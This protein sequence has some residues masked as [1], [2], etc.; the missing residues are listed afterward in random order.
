MIARR[1]G[2]G[3][4]PTAF[5]LA[6]VATAF[7]ALPIPVAAQES[8]ESPAF[9]TSEYGAIP[10]LYE[11]RPMP[12]SSAG[13]LILYRLSARGSVGERDEAAWIT[14]LLLDPFSAVEDEVFL[15]D[16]PAVLG[17]LGFPE[18]ERGRYSYLDL[19]PVLEPL[20]ILAVS[21]SS[22][23]RPLDATE[24]E[25][26]ALANNVRLFEGLA[27]TFDVFRAGSGP[28]GYEQL[29]AGEPVDPAELVELP[30]MLRVVPVLEDGK[31]RWVTPAGAV[32][33]AVAAA[34]SLAAHTAAV[35]AA[36]NE[37]FQAAEAGLLPE[38][39][40]ALLER[41]ET[42]RGAFPNL[43]RIDA[44]RLYSALRPTLW[45]GLAALLALLL[46]LVVHRR[47]SV[48]T[49]RVLLF[50]SVL[51]LTAH[52]VIRF[53]IMRRPPVTDLPSSFLFVAWVLAVAGTV[54]SF[55]KPSI[56]RVGVLL[57]SL[58]T[59]VLLYLARLVTGAS[60]RFGVVQAVLD[61]N[62]WLTTHV[63]VVTG[64]YA[65]IIASGVSGHIYLGQRILQPHRTALHQASFRATIM[66]MVIGLALTFLG[67]ILGGVWADQSWGRFWGWDPKENGALL[68]I[69]W[70]SIALHARLTRWLDQTGFAAA[71]VFGVAVVFFS[72]LGVNLMGVGLHSYGFSN[73]SFWVLIAVLVFEA[74]YAVLGWALAA[75]RKP[76]EGMT[77]VKI[78]DVESDGD[79]RVIVLS[80][81]PFDH[82]AGD[83]IGVRPEG[84]AAPRPF[85]LMDSGDGRTR[86]L[87]KENGSLSAHLV[88]T[89]RAGDSLWVSPPAGEFH[90]ATPR[91]RPV[92]M[93]AGGA[94]IAPLIG[95]ARESIATGHR[96]ILIRAGRDWLYQEQLV[97]ELAARHPDLVIVN[98][99]SRPDDSWQGTVGRVSHETLVEKHPGLV[100]ERADWYIC[101]SPAFCDAGRATAR[102]FAAARVYE[103]Q[104]TPLAEPATPPRFRARANVAGSLVEILPGQTVLEAAIASGV[105]LK[106]SCMSGTCGEC[107]CRVKS[108]KVVQSV[109]PA[110]A[111]PGDRVLT[112]VAYPAEADGIIL[113]PE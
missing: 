112:C 23:D 113:D 59:L 26:V 20:N 47:W 106:H 40:D 12:L 80:Q 110:E 86:L 58:S 100:P 56:A 61:T 89:A 32:A 60:D 87:V 8:G 41:F 69:L 102:A 81:L 36:W 29:L 97:G 75:R 30:G 64:G 49:V 104:F 22:V 70:S 52:Q 50:V 91:N 109:V 111:G 28:S 21:L 2:V 38:R 31:T 62:F 90:L 16:D 96:T 42:M 43:H 46:H 72:W 65:G 9:D 83:Y 68:I 108:G 6:L 94:G 14:R 76:S 13:R 3:F 53:I 82:R 78:D 37:L 45:A 95:L 4:A 99:L 92:V 55:R 85:S 57:A 48:P 103:E 107:A 71:A 11:G 98:V 66:L 54:M 93:L 77:R 63:L 84:F 35:L 5:A 39:P 33:G 67:T 74:A 79:A 15:V 101:G 105:D 19:Y 27:S 24:Q 34:D 7:L 88:H 51:L 73:A 44:E 17:S 18:P 10:V 1:R 25:I